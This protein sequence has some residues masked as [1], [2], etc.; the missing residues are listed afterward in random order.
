MKPIKLYDSLSQLKQTVDQPIITIY[1]CGPTVYD[2]IHLG[3]LRPVLIFDFLIRYLK[4]IG[5]Q[6]TY[7]HNITDIDDKI[8]AKATNLGCSAADLAAKYT[9]EYLKI[10]KQMRLLEPDHLPKVSDYIPDIID[11]IKLLISRGYAYHID[12]DVLFAIDQIP[13]YGVLSK[14]KQELLYQNTRK[15]KT[16][17]KHN[18]HDFF[19]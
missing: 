3:N 17:I 4:T 2:D 14:Q 9:L 10:I 13:N 19:L 6:V 11:Y 1:N 7:I 5:C 15:T 16:T 18:D 12:G 8:V